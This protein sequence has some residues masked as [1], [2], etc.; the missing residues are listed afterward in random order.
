MHELIT[1][2][3]HNSDSGRIS[4]I[5][6]S[7]GLPVQTW[8]VPHGEPRRDSPFPIH[9]FTGALKPHQLCSPSKQ[10]LVHLTLFHVVN[11]T[12]NCPWKTELKDACLGVKNFWDA[13]AG[14]FLKAPHI[15]IKI[16]R[17]VR[18]TSQ[19]S[20]QSCEGYWGLSLHLHLLGPSLCL[21]EQACDCSLK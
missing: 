12:S 16:V 5:P 11:N 6:L 14:N 4:S 20:R 9:W 18:H 19:S 8:G 13:F 17:Y 15:F 7:A 2:R 21:A 10:C 1:F 3:Y